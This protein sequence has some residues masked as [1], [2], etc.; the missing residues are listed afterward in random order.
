MTNMEQE[1]N[2][3]STS[4]PSNSSEQP[5]SPTPPVIPTAPFRADTTKLS[6]EEK[7][8]ASLSYIS[9]L[10]V[11]PLVLRG[12][13]PLIHAHAKQGMVLFG[14]EAVV[15]FLLFL[16]ESFM[17]AI[18]PASTI[19]LVSGLGGL[20]WLIFAALSLICIYFIF[21]DKKWDIPFLAK[22]AAKIDI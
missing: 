8:F 20:A 1:N 7:V 18:A 22:L 15:W 12:T 14:A 10:F 5:V 11:V 6:T 2:Q 3:P 21:R 16:L 13:N 9:V 17:G 19:G 4:Q